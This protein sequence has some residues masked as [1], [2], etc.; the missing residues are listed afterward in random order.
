MNDSE[1]DIVAKVGP[2]HLPY[3]IAEISAN[4]NGK[5]ENAFELITKAKV[6]GLGGQDSDLHCRYNHDELFQT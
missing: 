1:L 2:S 6:W 3:I 4:H 5:I